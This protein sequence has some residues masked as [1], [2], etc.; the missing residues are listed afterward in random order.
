MVPIYAYKPK[1][2]LVF[3]PFINLGFVQK[4]HEIQR[5]IWFKN[6][7]VKEDRISLE[8][9]KDTG[10]SIEPPFVTIQPKKKT[11]FLI[12]YQFEE[13]GIFRGQINIKSEGMISKKVIDVTAT[14]VDFFVFITTMDGM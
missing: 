12:K 8:V 3:E 11:K 7:G 5:E 14:V 10:I 6:E 1:A 9:E 4:G 13:P 2:I